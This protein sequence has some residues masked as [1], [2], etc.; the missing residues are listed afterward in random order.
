V[1]TASASNRAA[2]NGD[3]STWAS[4]ADVGWRAA[5]AA[6]EAK[7]DASTPSG[8]PKRVPMANF[9]PGRVEPTAQR[10][11]AR[12]AAQRNPDAV[13]GVL[14]SYRSGL[15]QGRQA[16]RS[17]HSAVSTDVDEQEEM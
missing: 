8:L 5:Q 3:S 7:I 15:E 12:P 16:T 14:S 9:V 4:P 10:R 2:A 11:S 17:R 1:P 6:A 13:R